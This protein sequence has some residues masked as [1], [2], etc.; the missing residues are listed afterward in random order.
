[1]TEPVELT[2]HLQVFYLDFTDGNLLLG[3]DIP[4]ISPRLKLQDPSNNFAFLSKSTIRVSACLKRV[5]K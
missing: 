4:N 3:N 5:C 2:Q 1:M